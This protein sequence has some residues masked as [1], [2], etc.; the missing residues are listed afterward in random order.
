MQLRTLVWNKN[1]KAETRERI[2]LILRA[3]SPHQDT[4][5]KECQKP[6]FSQPTLLLYLRRSGKSDA[7]LVPFDTLICTGRSNWILHRKLKC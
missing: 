1:T 5:P 3:L 7:T 4:G 2:F 6:P